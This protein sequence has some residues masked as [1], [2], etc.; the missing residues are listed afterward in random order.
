ML[1]VVHKCYLPEIYFNRAYTL[2]D[3][4]IEINAENLFKNVSQISTIPNHSFFCFQWD[5]AHFCG[6]RDQT[7]SH[8]LSVPQNCITN[9]TITNSCYLALLKTVSIEKPNTR[10]AWQFHFMLQH[11]SVSIN[12][13]KDFLHKSV[14]KHYKNKLWKQV[15]LLL[16]TVLFLL[17]LKS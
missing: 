6:H 9:Y 4:F 5:G 16:K 15:S 3:Y 7:E 8:V 2:F 1:S 13:S 17:S 14:D 10:L 11:T 12:L